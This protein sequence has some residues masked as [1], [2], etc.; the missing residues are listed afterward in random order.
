MLLKRM[1]DSIT[2]VPGCQAE[3]QPRYCVDKTGTLTMNQMSVGELFVDDKFLEPDDLARRSLP[4]EFHSLVEFSILASQRDPFDAIE[5]ALH[6]LGNE[7]PSM[8]E[9]IHRD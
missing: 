9:H 7:R 5:K 8:M 3:L 4:E 6:V 1:F 2:Y